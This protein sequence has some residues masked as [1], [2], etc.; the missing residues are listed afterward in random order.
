MDNYIKRFFDQET[1][2]EIVIKEL[3][4]EKFQIFVS[5]YGQVKRITKATQE[6]KIL[7]QSLSEGY[8]TANFSMMIPLNE[9][10][11]LTFID[12]RQ[13]IADQKKTIADLGITLNNDELSK[14]DKK[15]IEQKIAESTSVLNK[16]VGNYKKKYR[17][18]EL[19][20]KQTL[21]LLVH[22]VVAQNFNH[23]PTEDH[24][25][26]A[27][28]DFDKLNNHHSNLKWM[29]RQENVEHQK[30]S[31]Y[32]IKSKILAT[33]K[34]MPNFSKL[35]V[36]Q[37]MILKKRL[38]NENVSLALL[39]KRY[40]VSQTQLLRIKRGENWAKIPAAL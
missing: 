39:A 27:H 15:D 28:L 4:A 33:N 22:R 6:Q 12:A 36:N 30:K 26:V 24:N 13:E 2:Q 18:C 21:Y 32:V 19:K 9:K 14:N 10:E 20:R 7:R 11:T 1:W 23:Q 35:T 34:L 38:Q 5:N 17:K 3:F 16:L 25:L 40:K 31:P 29:T 37:V 8:P